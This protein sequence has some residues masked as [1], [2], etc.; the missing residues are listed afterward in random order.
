M[1]SK[2]MVKFQFLLKKVQKVGFSSK[3]D[4]EK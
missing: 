4:D 1:L 3:N 2:K